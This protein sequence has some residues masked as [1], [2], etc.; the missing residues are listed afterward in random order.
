MI[1]I[2]I[3]VDGMIG[4]VSEE[5]LNSAMTDAFQV[6]K[7]KSNHRQKELSICAESPIPKERIQRILNP[8]GFQ[9]LDYLCK[10]Q[11]NPELF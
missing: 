5:F 6:T 11:T 9:V 1:Q 2:D 8:L 10:D 4:E 7:I 3:K